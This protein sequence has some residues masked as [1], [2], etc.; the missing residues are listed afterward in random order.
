MPWQGQQRQLDL[1][2][3]VVDTNEIGGFL[4]SCTNLGYLYAVRLLVDDRLKVLTPQKPPE[5]KK[6]QVQV[7]QRPAIPVTPP[8]AVVQPRA[9]PMAEPKKSSVPVKMSD[10]FP[11]EGK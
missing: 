1:E 6:E 11:E 9:V 2:F 10:F 5:E 8:L 7:P 3:S 4:A